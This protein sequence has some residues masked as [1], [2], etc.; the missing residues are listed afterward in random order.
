M[1]ETKFF[2]RLK[3]ASLPVVVDF[4]APWCGPCRMIEPV[5]DKLDI[6]YAG[7][8][9]VWKIN[10]DEQ[11]EVLRSLRIYGIPLWL[12]SETV[13]KLLDAP[14]Q[15]RLGPCQVCSKLLY[16]AMLLLRLVL[17]DW[18]VYSAWQRVAYSS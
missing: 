11:P 7:R 18:H 6:E 14:A 15:L 9:D 16:R 4:W 8:V 13:K 17:A 1:S 3:Q 10:A 2:E 5:M 12:H